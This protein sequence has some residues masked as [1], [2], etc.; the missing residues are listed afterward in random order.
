LSALENLEGLEDSFTKDEIGTTIH[1]LPSYKSCGPDGFI[2]EFL[3]RCWPVV[4]NDFYDRCQGFYDGKIC[5]QSINASHIVLVPKKDN[6]RKIGDF[7]H[8]S[9]LN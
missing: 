2:G 1:N 9:L 4:E 7:R 8:I 5:M 3:K 6:P